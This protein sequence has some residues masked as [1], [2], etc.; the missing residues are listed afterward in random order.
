MTALLAL[1]GTKVTLGAQVGIP[2]GEGTVYKVRGSDSLVAKIYHPDKRTKQRYE[3]LLAMLDNPPRE[4]E[5]RDRE[6]GRMVPTIAWP[7]TILIGPDKRFKGFVM[8]ALDH[9]TAGQLRVMT[10]PAARK[11]LPWTQK[12]RLGYRAYIALNL[13]RVVRLLHETNVVIGDFNEFNVMVSPTLLVTIID[14]DSMQIWDARSGKH[15]LC[16]V[17]AGGYTA[18]E[19]MGPNK[20]DPRKPIPERSDL[21]NLAVHIYF[22]LMEKHPFRNGI[23]SAG[24][25]RPS[26]EQFAI[27]GEWRGKAHGKLKATESNGF[28]PYHFLP[29]RITG[30]FERAFEPSGRNR[31]SAKEWEL[32]LT[33]FIGDWKG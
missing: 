8:S 24:G 23:Y 16:G 14:C 20:L 22:L 12:L 19:L 10:N 30:L 3:K 33:R 26:A 1:N 28:D 13:S 31:P 25:E 5:V 18:P 29:Y 4:I 2:G 17:T 6:T 32:E 7:R 11:Q 9:T 27:M 21:F 15:H